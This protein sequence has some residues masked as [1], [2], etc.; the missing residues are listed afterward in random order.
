MDEKIKRILGAVAPRER[1]EIQAAVDLEAAVHEQARLDDV[2]Y[3]M[4]EVRTRQGRRVGLPYSYLVE[5]SLEFPRDDEVTLELIFS[6]RRVL[7]RGRNLQSVFEQVLGHN[8][9]ILEEDAS[10][11][12]TGEEFL[13]YIR[14]IEFIDLV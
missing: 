13:P 11:F 7:V 6:S 12:D 14:E 8:M 3:L 1:A 2:Q 9:K 5:V 10:E 4:L